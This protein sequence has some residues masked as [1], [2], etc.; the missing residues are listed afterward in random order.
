MNCPNVPS[1]NVIKFS[2]LFL[3][4]NFSSIY[5]ANMPTW[6]VIKDYYV[7]VGQ[8]HQCPK[9]LKLKKVFDLS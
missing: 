2:K 8:D 5:T 9:L 1:F 7:S 6:H 3:V 4:T